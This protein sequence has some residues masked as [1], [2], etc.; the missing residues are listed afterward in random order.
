MGARA[1]VEVPSIIVVLVRQRRIQRFN[2]TSV[3]YTVQLK[4]LLSYCHTQNSSACID[5]KYQVL[6][7]PFIFKPI[8]EMHQPS[9]G[10]AVEP[11]K[12]SDIPI[13]SAN[14]NKKNANKIHVDLC[15]LL[16]E[17]PLLS[18]TRTSMQCTNDGSGGPVAC[19]H[20][21]SVG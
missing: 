17:L 1:A 20:S 10:A 19:A 2:G 3:V 15:H 12:K 11:T 21:S 18:W 5:E 7:T 6:F 16:L 14:T 4:N 9:L 13:F 8:L